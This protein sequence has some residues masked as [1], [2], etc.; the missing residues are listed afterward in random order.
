MAVELLLL[1]RLPWL[2]RPF[3]QLDLV[4][5]GV[6]DE[7]D[8]RRAALDGARLARDGPAER[9]CLAAHRRA[10]GRYI[11]YADGDVAVGVAQLIAVHAVVERQLDFGMFGVAPVAEKGK[12]VLLV[13][14]PGGA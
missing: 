6:G 2:L 5:V 8:D 13:R 11:G 12:V 14:A 1:R 9:R 10:S 3:D 7:G 4:A